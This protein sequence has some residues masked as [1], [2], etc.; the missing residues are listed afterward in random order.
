MSRSRFLLEGL[1][2][3]CVGAAWLVGSIALVRLVL[4]PAIG[5]ALSLDE[6]ATSLVRRVGIFIAIVLAYW[7]FVRTYEKRV[8]SELEPRWRWILLAGVVGSAS[9]GVTILVLFATGQVQLV[10]QREWGP[11]API[12]GLIVIAAVIEELAYRGLLFRILEEKSG[13]TIAAL[14]A[15]VIFGAVHLAN[16]GV[17]GVTLISVTLAGL[18][19]SGVFVVT[20]NLWAAA[21]HHAAWN[22][23]IFLTGLPLSGDVLWRTQSPGVTEL[24]GST[25]WTGGAFGPEDSA[26]NLAVSLALCVGLWHL[27]RRRGHIRSALLP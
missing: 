13:T 17:T 7:A 24:K 2:R 3:L 22:A 11:A 9:I 15:A 16:H 25:F 12:L 19:W 20:R 27:A 6:Q 8:V 14:V 21:A 10:S 5:A 26:L 18:I 1:L 23:T 4:L